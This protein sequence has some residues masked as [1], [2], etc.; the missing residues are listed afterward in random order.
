MF[1]VSWALKCMRFSYFSFYAKPKI[2]WNMK[3]KGELS[4]RRAELTLKHRMKIWRGKNK[5]MYF[6]NF[7]LVGRADFVSDDFVIEVK[8]NFN[9]T[10]FIPSL[11]QLNLYMLMEGKDRGLLLMGNRVFEVERSDFIIKQSI[12]YFESL[13][14]HITEFRIPEKSVEYCYCCAFKECCN[15]KP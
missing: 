5:I 7:T 6:K 8:S 9:N 2:P 14:K 15:G 13:A 10:F 12:S 1:F 3:V 11:A 4:E